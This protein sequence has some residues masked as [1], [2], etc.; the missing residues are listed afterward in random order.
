MSDFD[1]LTSE[2]FGPGSPTGTTT[3]APQPDGRF[4]SLT[5]ELFGPQPDPGLAIKAA[6]GTNPDQFAKAKAQADRL[7]LPADAV[8]QSPDVVDRHLKEQDALDTLMGMPVSSMFMSEPNNAKLAHDDIDALTKLE[9]WFGTPSSWKGS[10]D[11]GFTTGTLQH[12]QALAV[13]DERLQP[14]EE[15]KRRVAD[16]GNA[17]KGSH[18]PE[19]GFDSFVASAA[20]IFGQMA[21]SMKGPDA[22]ATMAAGAVTGAT[23]ASVIPVPG[24]SQAGGALAGAGVG[25]VGHVARDTYMVETNLAYKELMDAGIDRSVAEPISMVVGTVNAGLEIGGLT[26]VLAP[27]AKGAKALIRQ[28][29][30]E[31]LKQLAKTEVLK[32]AGKEYAMGVVAETA[33]EVAQEISQILGESAAGLQHNANDVVNRLLGIAEKTAKG[34]ALLGLPGPAFHASVGTYQASQAQKYHD[35]LAEAVTTASESKLRTR[36]PEAFKQFMS[37]LGDPDNNGHVGIAAEPMVAYLQSKGEDPVTFFKNTL[38]VPLEDLQNAYDRGGDVQVKL[39]ELVNALPESPHL[40]ATL[41][42]VR[43]TGDAMTV[44]EATVATEARAKQVNAEADKIAGQYKI[45]MQGH[46]DTARTIADDVYQ[47]VLAT[48]RYGSAGA[49]QVSELYGAFFRTM[50]AQHTAEGKTFDTAQFYQDMGLSIKSEKFGQQQDAAM[51]AAQPEIAASGVEVH[52]VDDIIANGVGNLKVTDNGVAVPF[53]KFAVSVE[54]NRAEVGFVERKI[55]EGARGVGVKAYVALGEALAARGITLEASQTQHGKGAELWKRL[56]A[57]GHARRVNGRMQFVP[58]TTTATTDRS[59]AATVLPDAATVVPENGLSL[60]HGSGRSDLSPAAVEIIRESGQKQGKKGRVYGGLYLTDAAHAEQAAEY[61][62]MLGGAPTVYDVV[63]KPGTKILRKSGDI[64]RLS[65]ADI[66]KWVG[67]GYGLVVGK[68]PRGRTEYV[69]IDKAAIES[70]GQQTSAGQTFN[71]TDNAPGPGSV[72]EHHMNV[73]RAQR[74]TGTRVVWQ[75]GEK[76]AIAANAK[77]HGI[78]EADIVEHV[79]R[80]K[81]AHPAA[82]GWTPWVYNKTEVSTQEVEDENGNTTTQTVVDHQPKNQSYTYNTDTNGKAFKKGTPEYAAGVTAIARKLR[83][84]VAGIFRRAADQNDAAAITILRQADWYR[85]M[86]TRLRQEFGG[87]GDLFA[88]LLGATSPNTPV[89]GNWDNAVLS[90]QMASR[91]DFDTLIPQWV[92]WSDRVD[93]VEGE[94]RQWFSAEMANGRTKKAIKAD[95]ERARRKQEMMEARALPEALLPKKPNGKNFGFNGRNV[96]RAMVDLWRVVKAADPDITLGGTKPKAL[97]FSGNLIGFRQ[98]ATIDVWAAR[99]LQRLAKGNRIPSEAEQS[100]NGEMLPSG[101]TTGQFGFGQDVMAEATQL[102]RNDPVLAQHAKLAGLQDDDLQAVAWFVEKERWARD[103]ATSAQGEGGSFEFEA[104]LAGIADRDTVIELRRV[105]DSSKSTAT[106]KAQATAQLDGIK[107]TVDRYYAGLSIQQSFATQGVDFLPTDGDMAQVAEEVRTAI[108]STGDGSVLASK[109]YSTEG[110]YGDPERSFDV[111]VVANEAYDPDALMAKLTEIGRRT[112]QDSVFLSRVLRE[113]EEVDP[114]RHRPGI[115]VYF[116]DMQALDQVQ[117][118]LDEIAKAGVEF[119]TVVVDGRRSPEAMSGAMPAAVGIRM[120]YVPEFDVR[121]GFGDARADMSPE[122]ISALMVAKG[123]ELRNLADDIAGIEGVSFAGRFWYD[124]QVRFSHEY[125]ADDGVAA[126]TAEAGLRGDPGRAG[127]ERS[128]AGSLASADRQRREAEGR[129]QD[130][131]PG[132]EPDASVDAPGDIDLS[133]KT[134]SEAPQA[135]ASSS[136]GPVTLDQRNLDKLGFYSQAREAVLASPQDKMT[137]EQWRAQMK[138]S[139]VKDA[140]LAWIA[141]L[142]EFLN[143]AKTVS[144]LDLAAFIAQNGIKLDEV[145]LDGSEATSKMDELEFAVFQAERNVELIGQR[146]EEAQSEEEKAKYLDELNA[147]AD[148][149]EEAYRA[150]REYQISAEVDAPDGP[151]FTQWTMPGGESQ[152]EFYVTLPQADSPANAQVRDWLVPGAHRTRNAE[153]DTRLV[154]RIRVNDRVDAGGKKTLF[155]EEI[156]GDRQQEARKRGYDTEAEVL[157][158][159]YAEMEAKKAYHDARRELKADAQDVLMELSKFGQE[160]FRT[161]FAT[162]AEAWAAARADDMLA[163]PDGTLK[164]N[165]IVS[166]APKGWNVYEV[167]TMVQVDDVAGDTLT[168]NKLRELGTSEDLLAR[169]DKVAELRTKLSELMYKPPGIPSIPYATSKEWAE[170]AVKRVIIRAVQEGY[171]SVSWTPGDVQA[172]RYDLSKQIDQIAYEANPDG[173]VFV[174]VAKDGNVTHTMHDAD[175]KTVAETLGKEIADKIFA[176][177]GEQ[178][179]EMKHLRGLD[180]KVGGE[181]MKGFYDKMLPEIVAKFTKKIDPAAKVGATEVT[182]NDKAAEDTALLADLGVGGKVP[183]TAQVW[184]LPITEKMKAEALA[185]LPMFQEEN[186]PDP[187]GQI[188]FAGSKTTVALFEH[189]DLSTLLHETGHLFVAMLERVANRPGAPKA[190]KANYQAMLDWVGAKSA[191]DLDVTVAGEAAR[192]KQ[193]KLATTFEA[194]LLRGEAP[195]VAL[196]GAFA[197]FR[198]WLKQ[199]YFK[200]RSL[201]ASVDPTIA[202]VFDRMLATDAEI[203]QMAAFNEAKPTSSPSIRSL[204]TDSQRA[205][206]DAALLNAQ[207]EARNERA[208]LEAMV[209]ARAE[210]EWWKQEKANT[211]AD[212]ENEVWDRPA[213]RAFWFLTRGEARK[214]DTPASIRDLRID[215]QTLLDMGYTQDQLDKLPRSSRRVYTETEGKAADPD[216][217]AAVLGF[218]SGRELVDALA[219]MQPITEVVDRET[220]QR[221]RDKHGDATVDGTAQRKTEEGLYGSWRLK[222]L[223]IEMDALAGKI[224]QKAPSREVIKAAVDRIFGNQPTGELL[225][226]LKYQAA[227]VRAAKDAER[228]AAAGD[229]QKAFQKK[230]EQMINT[231]LF[232]RTLKA[233]DEVET[234]LDK[235]NRWKT[236]KIDSKKIDPEFVAKT[237]LLLSAYEVG[238][239]SQNQVTKQNAQLVMEF[240]RKA[241]AM[242]AGVILPPDIVT[243][244][245]TEADGTP[246]Y[247]FKITHWREMTLPELRG[248]RDMAANLLHIGR[249]NSDAAKAEL[250]IT[251]TKLADSILD[252]APLAKVKETKQARPTRDQQQ[253]GKWAKTFTAQHRKLESIMRQ[254]DGFMSLG[255]MWRTIFD[256]LAQGQDTKLAMLKTYADK[257]A[258]IMNLYTAKEKKHF[259]TLKSLAPIKALGDATFTHEQRLT[260]LLNW[261]SESSRQAILDDDYFRGRFGEAWNEAAINEILSTLS[262]KDMTVAEKIWALVN[263]SWPEVSEMERRITGVAPAKIEATPVTV[264]GK[265]ISGGYYPLKYDDLSDDRARR[266]KEEE[267]MKRVQSGGFTRAQTRQGF[268]IARVGS[269]GR[270]VR[271]DMGVLAQH[272]AEVAHSLSFREAVNDADKLMRQPVLRQAIIDTMGDEVMQTME[273]LLVK[274]AGGDLPG[275]LTG[276]EQFLRSARMNVTTAVMGMNLR[277]ILS[278]PTALTQSISR[279]G[280]RDVAVGVAKMWGNPAKTL[281]KIKEVNALSPYMRDRAKTMTRELHDMTTELAPTMVEKVRSGAFAGMVFVDVTTVAYPTWIGA[282]ER[283][284]N[285][286]ESGIDAGNEAD[287]IKFADSTVRTTQGSGGALNLSE[288]QQGSELMKLAT[289]FYSFFN[290]AYNLEAEAWAKAK[291]IGGAKGGAHFLGQTALVTIIPAILGGLLLDKLPKDDADDPTLEWA[292]WTLHQLITYT[293]GM[294]VGVRDLVGSAMNGMGYSITPV[295]SV[296][297]GVGQALHQIPKLAAWAAEWADN[298]SMPELSVKAAENF[299]RTVGMAVGFPGTN[300]IVRT[301]DYLWKLANDK[302]QDPPANAA[303][304]AKQMLL[305]GDKK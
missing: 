25:M 166:S 294:V 299:A 123:K 267:L 221:M 138:K 150:L 200:V 290:T 235:L 28:G 296:G 263:S 206:F 106:E 156:Q 136:P 276:F 262:D 196:Q 231:E 76:E 271:L 233:R 96:V 201:G 303:E 99:L 127:A 165:I 207:D 91:G 154:V 56:E 108:Y 279:I 39:A 100:V 259:N 23:V 229:T 124:T 116:R 115:E 274:I 197:Q 132:G 158:R 26:V 265:T 53:D 163:K 7:G 170:L 272:L 203:A 252:N 104:D 173:S 214:G 110:R 251:A 187:L 212:V 219:S 266:E 273:H 283:A 169:F 305:T 135:G 245:G 86:R 239:K 92:A 80:R 287:A 33:T 52:G 236:K 30:T 64:T 60:L 177:E 148:T 184:S 192:E 74:L 216:V 131:E 24:V 118:I 128:I 198:A 181:G 234:I 125:G 12:Q 48:G 213:Y 126:G 254:L 260:I 205:A 102:I 31:S 95:P 248:L 101:G 122:E 298:G 35:S 269:G 21:E 139:G 247:E 81:L 268:T 211:R 42:N 277:S 241:Q 258:E 145:V 14:S 164:R 228:A 168:M 1:T 194:Y 44:T 67:E 161:D 79:R 302:L 97:N 11:A 5:N 291:K 284:M 58:T 244:V 90:L 112:N 144:K 43:E 178:D 223:Q 282:Y 218:E 57:A 146:Y 134:T 209:D 47:Q 73:E 111:E 159:R 278:Q 65:K 167:S 261:G 281:Q 93:Q 142:D 172:D 82:G 137:A 69:V 75:P 250:E 151:K 107:R 54:G 84:D 141:G 37:G 188:R 180:L 174:Q 9:R 157:Q 300:Q 87:L 71:Q 189:A 171:D 114:T 295:E 130:R 59:A 226:P 113:T 147:A 220:D 230:R 10:A 182:T 270:P 185:G 143:S 34:M 98:R 280:A 224:G 105:I 175:Q 297:K 133:P 190:V 195:S 257:Y 243:M 215:K 27:F 2:L 140:E 4:Q 237:K 193:E 46:D 129:Q 62:K 208:A 191:A 152:R 120:Q 227:A 246:K 186:S 103:N 45:D 17:I 51:I 285:G 3:P 304:A 153:A 49:R 94:F 249:A 225:K 6:V 85:A 119:Y 253:S 68:D 293:G 55:G 13:R 61:A 15:A 32:T 50:A 240:I 199:V 20:E 286:R 38:G 36:D 83:D 232:R 41:A 183:A 289:M 275:H 121:Y 288:I 301:G 176:G 256:G 29:A 22:A 149:Q 242:G 88:D 63:V 179:G 72:G 255:P 160:V 222:A 89:R 238:S 109:A 66:E 78:P 8:A 204:L 40:E 117:P 210:E 162:E 202:K 292:K 70:M 16:I 217:L 77:K 264:N 19:E 18:A 155:I